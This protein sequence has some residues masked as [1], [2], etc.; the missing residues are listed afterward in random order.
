MTQKMTEI[1]KSI[2]AMANAGLVDFVDLNATREY[3][4][5]ADRPLVTGR[6]NSDGLSIYNDGGFDFEPSVS[7]DEAWEFM[8]LCDKEAKACAEHRT[9]YGYGKYRVCILS[10]ESG[11]NA[12]ELGYQRDTLEEAL[13]TAKKLGESEFG[14]VVIDPDNQWHYVQ[15]TEDHESPENRA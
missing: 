3:W 5:E 11:E 7:Y 6:Y 13:D 9:I 8:L 12:E 1:M 10:D 2:A 14:Y 4:A 15:D